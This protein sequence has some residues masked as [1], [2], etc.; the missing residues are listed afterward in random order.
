MDN[1]GKISS[2]DRGAV[3]FASSNLWRW[4]PI[5]VVS[6]LA[7]FAIGPIALEAAPGTAEYVISAVF[8]VLIV[9]FLLI[10]PKPQRR[11]ITVDGEGIHMPKRL[12]RKIPWTAV[13]RVSAVRREAAGNLPAEWEIR[14]RLDNPEPYLRAPDRA[15]VDRVF[16]L[17]LRDL[18]RAGRDRPIG[19]DLLAAIERFKP[20]ERQTARDWAAQE[21]RRDKRRL[22]P[23]RRVELRGSRF[24]LFLGWLAASAPLFL[25]YAVLIDP[26]TSAEIGDPWIAG[27]IGGTAVLVFVFLFFKLGL[28]HR[29]VA[30]SVG[31]EGLFIKE[32]VKEPMPWQEIEEIELFLDPLPASPESG[33]GWILRVKPTRLDA[34]ISRGKGRYL[35]KDG[36]FGILMR[37]FSLPRGVAVEDFVTDA[38]SPYMPITVRRR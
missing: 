10:Y 17:P 4:L 34:Y 18:A 5:L 15:D 33:A 14:F 8:F 38:I 11:T 21:W 1:N 19:D 26:T 6:V 2:N 16:R 12:V 3:S 25:A 9:I 22:E 23:G 29:P 24:E 31:P 37:S 35:E 20:V 28:W 27:A 32:R 13:E 7:I 30:F 36:S